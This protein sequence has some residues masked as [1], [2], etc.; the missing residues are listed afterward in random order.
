M[1]TPLRFGVIG[2]RNHA[3][4][5]IRLLEQ[6][7]DVQLAYV[8]HPE[9][10]LHHPCFTG[11]LTDLFRCHAVVIASPNESHFGY[12]KALVENCDGYIFC[13][14]PH[15]TR[16][17]D[18]DELDALNLIDKQRI[19][20]NFN[21]RFSELSKLLNEDDVNKLL[22]QMV[23]CQVTSTHGLAF[24]DAYI[25]SWRADGTKNLHAVTD[26]VAIHYIDLF[27]LHWGKP[28]RWAYYPSN[29]AQSGTSYDTCLLS[30]VYS[31]GHSLSIFASYACSYNEEITVYGTN[32]CLRVTDKSLRIY[33]PRDSLDENGFFKHPPVAYEQSFDAVSSYEESLR[34]SMNNFIMHVK[35]NDNI[36]VSEFQNSLTSNRFLLSM[37]TGIAT[38]LEGSAGAT[39]H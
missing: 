9:K 24:K 37:K 12:L 20:F 28:D 13:E 10:Q 18:I 25:N 26:T 19:F 33:S 34:T 23:H 38:Q 16:Q 4:R 27:G 11:D 5:L 14:K 2:Y 21:Y 7:Q 30:V 32:G 17:E 36:S 39:S 15:V 3:L 22:G 29:I 1:T 8:Y 31:S 6:R 35:R